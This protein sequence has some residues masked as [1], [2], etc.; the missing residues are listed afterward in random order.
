MTPV[1]WL[2]ST[3]YYSFELPGVKA[4][5]AAGCGLSA[6]AVPAAAFGRGA[7]QA[8]N[9]NKRLASKAAVLTHFIGFISGYRACL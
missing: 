9:A 5:S 7:A 6:G 3:T 8:E 2:A 4:G 1:R